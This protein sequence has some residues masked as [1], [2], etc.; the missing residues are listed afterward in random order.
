MV[1]AVL[2]VKLIFTYPSCVVLL[3]S[4]H[5]TSCKHLTSFFF[6]FEMK[7]VCVLKCNVGSMPQVEKVLNAR[8]T[9]NCSSTT[10]TLVFPVNYTIYPD[11]VCNLYIQ[12]L[13]RH[14]T[15]IK[16]DAFV[17]NSCNTITHH[18]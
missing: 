18:K 1:T 16:I 6:L 15:H 10:F 13:S 11:I 8:F 12:T 2:I 9:L 3:E 4:Y 17:Q 5:I 14:K 7:F